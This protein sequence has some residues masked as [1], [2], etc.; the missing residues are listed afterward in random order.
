[1]HLR[2]SVACMFW[3]HLTLFPLSEGTC[4]VTGDL[5][6]LQRPH[7]DFSTQGAFEASPFQEAMAPGFTGLGLQRP[8]PCGGVCRWLERTEQQVCS[9]EGKTVLGLQA[10]LHWPQTFGRPQRNLGGLK[11]V[12]GASPI[13]H[14]H[15]GPPN[16][17]KEP[18]FQGYV[19]AS[20][21]VNCLNTDSWSLL[22]S[23]PPCLQ[24]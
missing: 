8:P 12:P 10:L 23:Q 21:N 20:A 11:P 6:V 4:L 17:H 1:M 7:G 9:Q 18:P 13:Q 5:T 14:R 19:A 15:E 2:N 16:L 24:H 3:K 22:Q